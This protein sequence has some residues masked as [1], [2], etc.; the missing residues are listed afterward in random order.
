MRARRIIGWSLTGLAILL[1]LALGVCLFFLRSHYFAAYALGKI[2]E[3]MNEATGGKTQIGSLDFDLSTLTAH[4]YDVTLHGTEAANQLPLLHVDKLTVGLKI[5]SVL[6]RKVTLSELAIEHPSVNLLVSSNGKNNLPQPPA[7]RSSSNASVFDLAVGHTLLSHGEINYNDKQAPL[8]ADLHDLNVDVHFDVLAIRY[9]GSVSYGDG[10]LHYAQY[11]PLPHDLSATFDATPSGLTL[12]S[13]RLKVAS[14]T[15]SL[16]AKVANYSNPTADGTY[17]AKLHSED[18]ASMSPSVAPAGDVLLKGAMHYENPGNQPLLQGLSINGEIASEELSAASSDARLEVRKLRGKYQIAKG[19]LHADDIAAQLL[20]GSVRVSLEVQ[21]L[22]TTP[23]T[24]VTAVVQGI[25][26]A[27]MQQSIRNPQSRRVAVLASVS[28]SAS[29]SWAGS[30][31]NVRAYSNLIIRSSHAATNTNQIPVDGEIHAI[32]EGGRGA[33]TLRQTSLQTGS[34][35]VSGQG[36][37]SKRSNLQIRVSTDDLHQVIELASAFGLGGAKPPAISGAASVNASVRGPLQNP[38]ISGQLTAHNLQVQGGEWSSA[39]ATFEANPSRVQVQQA[40]LVSAHQGRASF[41]GSVGLRDWSY[42][43]SSPIRADLSVQQMPVTDLQR[44]ANVHYPISGDLSADLNLTGSQLNPAGSGSAHISK[45]IAYDEP[46]QN[47]ALKFQ[48]DRDTIISTLSVASTAGSVSADLSYTPRSKAYTFHINAPSV[49]LQKLHVLQA[50]NLQI[51]GTLR[52]SAQGKGTLDRPEFIAAIELPQLQ[53][54]QN[55]ISGLKAEVQ[56]ANQRA[57]LSLSSQAAQSSVRAQG[58]V[59]LDGDYDAEGSVD[60]TSIPLDLLLANYMPRVPQ[61][62]KGQ[63]EFHATIKGPLKNWSQ[64]E[65]HLTIPVL[66]A[67]Y[68]SL[69]IGEAGPI[70]A[71]YAHSVL[72]LQPAEIRGTGTDLR[73]QGSIP[74]GGTG[75]ATLTAN[76]TVDV[77]IA[78]IVA[79][80]VRSSGTVALNLRASGSSTAPVLQGQL[81]LQDI[82]FATDATPLG[83]EKLNGTLDI[84]NDHVQVSSLTGQVGGGQISAGGSIVFRPGVQFNLA[85]QAKSVR[86]RYPEGLRMLLDANLAF[87]G[88][89]QAS[90]LNGRV[91]VDSLSFTPDFDLTKFS[92]QFSGNT[93]PAQ[94]GFADNIK[95]AIGVQSKDNLSANSSQISIEGDANLQ[96]LGTAANPVI[97]GR[98]NLTSGELFYRNLRYQLQRGIIT[99]DNPTETEPKMDVSATT[100][101]EQ[102]NLTITLRG[103]LDKL[104]TTY[105]SDPPLATAD[106]INLLAQGQTTQEAAASSQSTDSIIASQAASQVTG[107]LQ[108]LAGIS[109]LQ[110]DP[111]IG[112]NNSNP[113]ARIAL[114]QRVTKDLLFTFSTDLSQPGTEVVQ[115]EYQLNKRWSVSVARDETGGVSVNGRYHTKF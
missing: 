92:D 27:A 88:T 67:S 39:T 33:L 74:F 52:A 100:T 9:S 3:D 19:S 115:G 23:S 1:L 76:G 91:L 71:D 64:L 79:S 20:G 32:Y 44:L 29:A 112:G 38:S 24:T 72:T 82:S 97:I 8:D 54:K 13:A 14:S 28:G 30:I 95:L 61:G 47:L 81:H 80:D 101:V 78:R 16:Q 15:I 43:V 73:V 59:S 46:L 114:Q 86:L 50:K 10:H 83:V 36:E 109:S 107:G 26:L 70:R 66:N 85:M 31:Q 48:A 40:S 63:T 42:L 105:T 60:T 104:E 6:Q 110:I 108:K 41:S 57:D 18:F 35:K 68:Q 75:T 65:A 98:T 12:D 45:A 2:V 90:T 53:L 21:H 56:V 102:Y 51:S 69:E 103:T 55:S 17:E 77:S 58:H 34:L 25:S 87:S 5:Q 89:T 11:Q 22:D 93:I 99:F 37:I 113:S 62:F 84:D 94:P 49:V 106:V 4:L 111:L 96:V 7:S